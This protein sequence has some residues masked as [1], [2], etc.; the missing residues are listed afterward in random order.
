MKERVRCN[1]LGWGWEVTGII[2]PWMEALRSPPVPAPLW[3]PQ[4]PSQ[5]LERG[6]PRPWHLESAWAVQLGLPVA[7]GVPPH[8]A[9]AQPPLAVCSSCGDSCPESPVP[10]LMSSLGAAWGPKPGGA[11]PTAR[12]PPSAPPSLPYSLSPFSSI[13]SLSLLLPPLPGPLASPPPQAPLLPPGAA[14]C[15][16]LPV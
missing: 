14:L 7:L 2:G 5:R 4:P 13:L 9:Q 1:L 10:G 3:I 12:S 8:R 11:V 16:L 6:C 15:Q